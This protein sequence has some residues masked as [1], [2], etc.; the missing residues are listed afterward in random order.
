M[1][2]EILLNTCGHITLEILLGSML[3]V[4]LETESLD[5]LLAVR[6]LSPILLRTLVTTD[7]DVL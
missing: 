1:V 6:T 3:L 2:V 4:G 7:V 5:S